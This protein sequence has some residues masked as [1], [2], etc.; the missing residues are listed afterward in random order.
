METNNSPTLFQM[1]EVFSPKMYSLIA[2]IIKYASEGD[3]DKVKKT[4]DTL[5]RHCHLFNKAITKNE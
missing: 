5:I 2:K 1:S 3:L 4:I